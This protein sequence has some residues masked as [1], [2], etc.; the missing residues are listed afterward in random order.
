MAKL[1]MYSELFEAKENYYKVCGLLHN[2][3]FKELIT[4]LQESNHNQSVL[5]NP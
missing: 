2:V 1:N 4:N 5:I 3:I